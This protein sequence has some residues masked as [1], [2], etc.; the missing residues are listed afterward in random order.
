[1]ITK[2]MQNIRNEMKFDY[3]GFVKSFWGP[4]QNKKKNT[5]ENK[6]MKKQ[7]KKK[8]TIQP[9][10]LNL[11]YPSPKKHFFS[12]WKILIYYL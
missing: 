6:Q 3:N 8:Q 11:L 2:K 5:K 12:K 4:K 7:N 1:M 10:L 9:L